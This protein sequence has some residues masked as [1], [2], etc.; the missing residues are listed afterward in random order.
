MKR[1]IEGDDRSQVTG[2]P[3]CLADY[4]GSG[5]PN[6]VVDAFVEEFQLQDLGF[7]SAEPA[8]TGRPS[9]HPAVLLRRNE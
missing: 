6:R 4:I 3:E 9:Y 8:A 5:N 2:L 7:E 1:F